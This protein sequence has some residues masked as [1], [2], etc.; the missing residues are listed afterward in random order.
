VVE[1]RDDFVARLFREEIER[2]EWGAIILDE[3]V[4]VRDVAPFGED[5]VTKAQSSG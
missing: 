1:L 5:G 2:F 4:A 3:A